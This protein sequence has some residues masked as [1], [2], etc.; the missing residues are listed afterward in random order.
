MC[1]ATASLFAQSRH[2]I[3]PELG[4]NA[5]PFEVTDLG[6]DFALGVNAGVRYEF[7]INPRF[8]LGA[9]VNYSQR[10]HAFDS[11][12]TANT[13]DQLSSLLEQ[14][15]G[16]VGLPE[17]LNLGS[18]IN[19]EGRVQQGFLEVPI[20]ASLHL[21]Q[22][23]ISAGPYAGYH[24][25]V[26]KTTTRR[27]ETP[28][29]QVID[30]GSL[31]PF[32]DLLGGLLPP[33]MEEEISLSKTKFGYSDWDYG[34]KAGIG[35][36]NESFNLRLLYSYGLPDYLTDTDEVNNRSAQYVQASVAYLFN[37]PQ[38]EEKPLKY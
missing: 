13:N 4:V 12:S 5:I 16:L 1:L 2:Y 14:F 35:Y 24:L 32:P 20:L 19:V 15:G 3:G 30:L 11:L 38:R 26:L 29:V 28:F 23:Q 10:F 21:G 9:G 18:N 27:T 8:S 22:F 34:F 31:L 17:G 33:A 37:L 6:R 25:N 36:V 7:R